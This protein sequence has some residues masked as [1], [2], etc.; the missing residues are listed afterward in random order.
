MFENTF[1]QVSLLGTAVVMS[2]GNTNGFL[3]MK[4]S[5]TGQTAS[6]LLSVGVITDK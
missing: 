5:E 1:L 6:T 3:K 4:L 2:Y